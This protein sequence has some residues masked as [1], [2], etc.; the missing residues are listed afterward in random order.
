MPYTARIR[1]R[2]GLLPR[3]NADGLWAWPYVRRLEEVRPYRPRAA[4]DGLDVTVGLIAS[5]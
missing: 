4:P 5:A 3:P 1:S 2:V